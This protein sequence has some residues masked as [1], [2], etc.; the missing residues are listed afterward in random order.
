MRL[1]VLKMYLLFNHCEDTFLKSIG[2]YKGEYPLTYINK[3]M[4][5][6]WYISHSI[7]KRDSV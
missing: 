3:K 2:V 7:S 4:G 5:Y 1:V 6:L